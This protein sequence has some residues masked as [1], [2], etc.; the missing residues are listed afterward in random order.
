[1]CWQCPGSV[2][3]TYSYSDLRKRSTAL[4]NTIIIAFAYGYCSVLKRLNCSLQRCGLSTTFSSYCTTY[5]SQWQLLRSSPKSGPGCSQ[6]EVASATFR[7][8][9]MKRRVSCYRTSGCLVVVSSPLE[10][11]LTPNVQKTN[12]CL[13]RE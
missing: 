11:E 8:Q 9:R 13:Y 2:P 5:K 1:M 10:L 3:L 12:T 6:M 4:S 7:R